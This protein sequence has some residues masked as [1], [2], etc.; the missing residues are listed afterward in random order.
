MMALFLG[1]SLLNI[2][3]VFALH[4]IEPRQ[5]MWVTWANQ[6]GVTDFCLSLQKASD[7][8]RTCLIGY[9]Y[10][11]WPDFEPLGVNYTAINQSYLAWLDWK[12]N[13]MNFGFGDNCTWWNSTLIKNTYFLQQL[14]YHLNESIHLPQQELD[15]WGSFPAAGP[16][17]NVSQKLNCTRV[18]P[19]LRP[20]NGSGAVMFGDEWK[21]IMHR[22]NV[23]QFYLGYQNVSGNSSHW[24]TSKYAGEFDV[25]SVTA[26]LLPE[27][28]FLICGDRAWP[29]IP[30]R[31]VG[32]PCYIGKLTMFAPAMRDLVRQANE[33]RAKR[34]LHDLKPDCNDNVN[35]G[36]VAGT[37]AL[38]FFLPGGAAAANWAKIKTLACWAVK[39][40][41]STTDIL[42]GLAT[43]V[44]SLRHAILQN[45]AAI[46]FLLLANGHGCQDFEG[47]CC[48]NLSDHSQS[49][50]RQLEEL[51][52]RMHHVKEGSS[53]IDSWFASLGING[54]L[55]D[56]LKQ[57]LSVLLLIGLLLLLLPC[58]LSCIRKLFERVTQSFL[59]Q[60]EKGGIVA[61]WMRE[62]GHGSMEGLCD[63]ALDMSLE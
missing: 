17:V 56:L 31:P 28:Y 34:S 33:S 25:E 57:G 18:R 42:S 11:H 37:V 20:I 49:I 27:G 15:L 46:D 38:S 26:K 52:N 9:P 24:N 8:F 7:P 5:N 32:G 58:I 36:T 12:Y 23:I 22:D 48:L 51:R 45:R 2:V 59:V 60:K 54:W 14:I 44:D 35:L 4:S 1:I 55:R 3:V 47:M 61:E 63:T 62:N 10:I 41:N 19:L 40:F 16:L 43:D 50:H 30:F 21:R 39:Q 53:G 13:D 29:A 6:S